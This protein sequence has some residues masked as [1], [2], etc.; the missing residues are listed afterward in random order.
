[1]ILSLAVTSAYTMTYLALSVYILF[2][3]LLNHSERVALEGS[4]LS[5]PLL[6]SKTTRE[7]TP[8]PG[9]CRQ[10]TLGRAT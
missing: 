10:A 4:V 7:L 9:V 1:M 8:G 5:P 2:L 3:A 6:T